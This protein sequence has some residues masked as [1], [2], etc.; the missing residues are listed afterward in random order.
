[1]AEKANAE[2]HIPVLL[3]SILELMA[4]KPGSVFIDATLGDGGHAEA[5]L[6]ASA[7]DGRLLGLD[8]DGEMLERAKKRLAS[9]D[10]RFLGVQAN[11][12]EIAEVARRENF[13][14]ADGIIFDLGVASWHF[15]ASGRGFSFQGDEP[16]DM[17]LSGPLGEWTAAEIINHVEQ[18]ELE[19]IFRE[20]GEEPEAKRIAAAIVKRR[21][22]TNT[23][24]LVNTI[25][26]AKRRKTKRHKATQTFQALRIAVNDELGSLEAALPEALQALRLGG[27]LAVIAYHSLEDRIVKRFMKEASS[28]G[29][30]ELAWKKPQVPEEDEIAE[31]PRSRSAKLRAAFLRME[32]NT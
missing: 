5:L 9:F 6:K 27:A 32:L 10:D 12:A 4:P 15:D 30:L 23:M 25:E 21:P 14:A 3:D 1:M 17:R 2:R 19:R 22:I 20:Y 26:E 16:L 11:F 8:R 24:M 29:M 18:Q 28:Q 13:P 31:N 7:P